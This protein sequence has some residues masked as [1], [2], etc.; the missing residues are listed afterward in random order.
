MRVKR[1][2]AWSRETITSAEQD[3]TH[4]LADLFW[5]RKPFTHVHTQMFVAPMTVESAVDMIAAKIAVREIMP[6][7]CA[8]AP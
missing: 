4:V 2:C 7:P 8:N 1:W 3:G 5:S 6:T